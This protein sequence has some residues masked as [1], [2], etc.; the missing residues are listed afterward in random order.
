MGGVKA[1]VGGRLSEVQRGFFMGKNGRGPGFPSR[2]LR[3]DFDQGGGTE[4]YFDVT[5]LSTGG[6]VSLTEGA[7]RRTRL[8]RRRAKAAISAGT[9]RTSSRA[10]CRLGGRDAFEMDE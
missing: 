9:C 7:A 6:K 4:G 3:V 10:G 1:L 2:G 5:L 8:R